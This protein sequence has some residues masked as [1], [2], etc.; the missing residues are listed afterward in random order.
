M[1]VSLIFTEI[2]VKKPSVKIPWKAVGEKPKEYLKPEYLP[3][4]PI[5]L[6]DPSRMVQKD[7]WAILSHWYKLV[8]SSDFGIM[9]QEGFLK[10][11]HPSLPE[12]EDE[13]KRKGR[14]GKGHKAKGNGFDGDEEDGDE[15]DDDDTEEDSEEEEGDSNPP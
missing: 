14:K 7:V 1:W 5:N 13:K 4:P 12:S 6:C 9:F 11:I 3:E 8:G 10:S 15:E 2:A